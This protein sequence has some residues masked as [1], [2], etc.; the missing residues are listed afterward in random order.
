MSKQ[1][2][3]EVRSKPGL[4]S[5]IARSLWWI[6]WT[7][8]FRPTPPQFHSWRCSLLKLFGAK[9]GAQVSIYPSVVVWAPWNLVI[10]DSATIGNRT[11]LYSVDR[12]DLGAGSIVSQGSHLCTASHNAHSPS[13]EL[14][15]A[16]ITVE[17]NAWIAA[18]C[19]VG[20]GVTVSEGAVVAARGV[21][22]KDVPEYTIVGGNPCAKIGE[23]DRLARNL[24]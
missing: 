6:T 15:T 21:V 9:I 16:P 3:L 19:F 2:S 10:E 13:F 20:P 24:L 4:K 5:K 11:R 17:A 14:L 1:T 23:R 12:I 8:L 22:T 7:C 18:D